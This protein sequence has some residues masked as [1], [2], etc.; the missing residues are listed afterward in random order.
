MDAI[1]TVILFASVCGCILIAK[2]FRTKPGASDGKII[3]GPTPVPLIGNALDVDFRRLHLSLYDMVGKYGPIFQINLLGQTVIVINDVELEKKAF[4]SAKYRDVFND[5]PG[6]FWGKYV[7]FGRSDI[8]FADANKKTHTKRKM[9]HRSLKF[10]GDGIAHFESLHEDELLHF[11]EV[12]KTTNKCDFNVH[13]MVMQSLSNTLVMLLIGKPP[14]KSDYESIQEI[15]DTGEFLLSGMGF[16]YDFMPFIRHL[17]VPT[18]NL[19]RRAIVARDQ[20]LN[21][22][23]FTVKAFAKIPTE[24]EQGLVKCLINLQKEINDEAGTEVITETDIKAMVFEIVGASQATSS[25]VIINAFALMLT[26]PH[27]AKKIQEEIENVVGS[28]RLPSYTDKEEMHYTMATTYEVLRYT[29]PVAL[30]IPHRAS[31]HHNFE[32][33]FVAKDSILLSNHWFIHHDPKLWDEP[34][35]FKPERFLD[36]E[37]KLLPLEDKMRRNLVPFYHW[38]QG[39]FRRKIRKIKDLFVFGCCSPIL[40]YQAS[41]RRTASGYKSKKLQTYTQRDY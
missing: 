10:Y 37:G 41:V 13:D 31:T 14:E 2:L 5:R 22:C 36:D 32:G 11:V 35:V 28:E 16:L 24:E 25:T 18:G 6:A 21:R 15:C 40:R 7:C 38:A 12:L 20:I 1:S 34:W 39:M 23:Y 27:A 19:Y 26:H 3:P 4:G 33:Y 8:A 9:F 17:P 29:T 30:N